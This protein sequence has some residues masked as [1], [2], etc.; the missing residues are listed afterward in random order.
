MSLS[1]SQL[2][3]KIEENRQKA[4][5]KKRKHA[6]TTNTTTASL[7]NTTFD[8]V[9]SKVG[10]ASNR[11]SSVETP[12]LKKAMYNLASE[13]S[14][15][16]STKT[17][18]HV[19]SET[20]QKIQGKLKKNLFAAKPSSQDRNQNQIQNP[21][22]SKTFAK[23]KSKSTSVQSSDFSL[24]SS[25]SA[26]DFSLASDVS[27]TCTGTAGNSVKLGG[28]LKFGGAAGEKALLQLPNSTTKT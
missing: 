6:S 1:T 10:D 2:K 19:N 12:D 13:L 5:E 17:S 28:P 25:N 11:S 24:A 16:R 18:S 26:S 4:L 14:A 3:Q 21:N 15:F 9:H 8:Y 7:I 22:N 23:S 20:D 27:D